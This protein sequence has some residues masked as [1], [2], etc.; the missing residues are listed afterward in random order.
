M[1]GFFWNSLFELS[2]RILRIFI[3]QWTNCVFQKQFFYWKRGEIFYIVKQQINKTNKKHPNDWAYIDIDIDKLVIMQ[4]NIHI[5]KE[6]NWGFFRY[7]KPQIKNMNQFHVNVKR[8]GG[9][10]AYIKAYNLFKC[11]LIE[12]IWFSSSTLRS[13]AYE[14]LH[15]SSRNRIIDSFFTLNFHISNIIRWPY[16]LNIYYLHQN[17]KINQ[18]MVSNPHSTFPF[19]FNVHSFDFDSERKFH[20]SSIKQIVGFE[21]ISEFPIR[22]NSEVF[23]GGDANFSKFV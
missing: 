11:N 20:T 6:N 2:F 8:D 19:F 22:W 7:Q 9:N 15:S 10:I 21:F 23:W 17:H 3:G 14:Q 18:T 16:Y 13:Y 5:S 12:M 1:V 4:N